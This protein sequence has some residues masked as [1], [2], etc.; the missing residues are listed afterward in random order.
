MLK[1]PL[2]KLVISVLFLFAGCRKSE[3]EKI[4][5]QAEPYRPSNLYPR[6]RLPSYFNRVAVM[7]VFSDSTSSEFPSYIDDLFLQELAKIRIFEPIRVTP[8]DLLSLFGKERIGSHQSLPED[9]FSKL[10]D[11]YGANGVLMIDLHSYKPYR[12][13]S[14]GIRAKLVDLKSGEFMWA[15]DE[16]IDG[17]DASV[18]V[19]A[20]N[21]QKTKHVQAL[22]DK[23]MGSILQSPRMFTKFMADSIFSTLPSRWKLSIC[24]ILQSGTS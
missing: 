17:G 10:N 11:K 23:T 12:P 1:I 22:S 16:T 21:F 13:I 5:A 3:Q 20:I 14:V 9:F 2:I 8:N 18:V 7:P 15:I 6:E 4:I 19:A 24:K